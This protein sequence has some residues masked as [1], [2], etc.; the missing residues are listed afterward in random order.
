MSKKPKGSSTQY[1]SSTTFELLN[2]CMPLAT[3]D[4]L[5]LSGLGKT[6]AS[7]INQ[8]WKTQ[9]DKLSKHANLIGPFSYDHPRLITDD[10]LVTILRRRNLK[11]TLS[12]GDSKLASVN[13]TD[14]L[15]E[16]AIETGQAYY[17]AKYVEKKP[18]PDTRLGAIR[19]GNAY[20]YARY[21]DES[22]RDDTREGAIRERRG[23]YYAR[24]VDKGPRADTREA[25]CR[26]NKGYQYARR[27]D[28][29]PNDCTR[30][31][32][33]KRVLGYYY[34]KYVDKCRR[35][36]T[37][38]A[39]GDFCVEYAELFDNG[40]PTEETRKASIRK[41]AA[42]LTFRYALEIEKGPNDLV[43]KTICNRGNGYI[44][45]RYA[46]KVD[47][48]ARADTRLAASL[49]GYA[50]QYAEFEKAPHDITRYYCSLPLKYAKEIDCGPHP[51][52]YAN[53]LATR[54][55]SRLVSELAE[56][57]L[58]FG[59]PEQWLAKWLENNRPTKV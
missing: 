36:D 52:T 4:L 39:S 28:Q 26:E 51:V 17:Y 10:Q 22:S 18:H 27:V 59:D 13:G 31:N 42:Y 15:R 53:L 45:M 3:A 48:V 58:L 34:A 2:A 49:D 8:S 37:A 50:L 35:P 40:Q 7:Q 16:L 6:G 30:Q 41:N 47:K 12:F 55:E 14:A 43:R 11:S 56:Y 46:E 24:Y 44:A 33:C 23:Y 9:K 29:A 21:V 1:L 25:A 54:G 57:L 38:L 20:P 5:S 32:A 19:E